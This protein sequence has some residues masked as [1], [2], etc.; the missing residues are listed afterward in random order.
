MA[1]TSTSIE[2]VAK[3][4]VENPPPQS[5][6]NYLTGMISKISSLANKLSSKVADKLLNPP[7]SPVYNNRRNDEL[8]KIWT[9]ASNNYKNAPFE[10]SLAEKNFYEFNNGQPDGPDIYNMTIIDRFA[11]TANDL[12]NNSIDKQQEF[13]A[14]LTENLKQYQGE[15][16]YSER[17]VQLFQV[18]QQENADLLKK[19]DM[20]NRILQTSERKV[21]YEVNDTT[22]LHTWRRVMLFLYYSALVS[23]IIFGNFIPDKLYLNK[24][25]W[26]I[27]VI[28][29]LV[30]IILNL[31]IK[32]IFIIGSLIG[33]WL[34]EPPHKDVYSELGRDI[35]T[36][37]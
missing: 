8:Q 33:Y 36:P 23:Y 18:R 29:S 17:T 4:L 27:L 32:W 1:S 2:T 5:T 22:S 31:V 19:I 28:V 26:L 20:Y 13:M 30:P 6:Q 12:K 25:V 37:P 21:V 35:P 14:N 16:L 10:L 11:N 34:K 24:I 7:G 9:D 3:D 15:K